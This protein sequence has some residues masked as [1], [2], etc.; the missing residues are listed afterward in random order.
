M[1]GSTCFDI[2]DLPEL[3]NYVVSIISETAAISK[4]RWILTNAGSV[5]SSSASTTATQTL[6]FKENPVAATVKVTAYIELSNGD[7][8]SIEKTINFQNSPCCIGSIIKNGA[9]DY[10]N[11]VPG[12]GA[13][14]AG[15][16]SGTDDQPFSPNYAITTGNGSITWSTWFDTTP[17]GNLCV[18]KQDT[19]APASS[20]A[21]AVSSCN[22]LSDGYN[23][24]YLPNEYELANIYYTIAGSPTATGSNT[25]FE[26]KT[27]LE[28]VVATTAMTT[29][30]YYWSSTEYSTTTRANVFYF[31]N[32]SR[33]SYDKT[34]TLYYARCV[35]RL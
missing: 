12:D 8:F 25:V 15:T 9:F 22:S 26:N 32:G 13:K 35:R 24:W 33:Y 31:G 29:S 21:N 20:W 23:D 28:V 2:R 11:D 17:K 19:G 30:T 10:I 27:N 18:Y 14:G 3:A 1:S 4:V 7:K 16:I 5:S 6:V 34:D